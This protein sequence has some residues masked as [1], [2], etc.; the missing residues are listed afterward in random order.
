MRLRC[1]RETNCE[2]RENRDNAGPENIGS[3]TEW[4]IKRDKERGDTDTT[5]KQ[6]DG[7]CEQSAITPH[8]TAKPTNINVTPSSHPYSTIPPSLL[9][10]FVCSAPQEH[11]LIPLGVSSFLSLLS[12]H[13]AL[14][15]T[16]QLLGFNLPFAVLWSRINALN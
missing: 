5:D 10:F 16:I 14:H 1:G 13:S 2:V 8:L 11:T 9:V 7:H 15:P 3:G 12:I 4:E 6:T